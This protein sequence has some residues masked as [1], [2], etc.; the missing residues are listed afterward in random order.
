MSLVLDR[1]TRGPNEFTLLAM[2]KRDRNR[3]PDEFRAAPW[4]RGG[5]H[6]IDDGI[7]YLYVQ[8]HV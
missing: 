8:T 6:L 1:S 2:P 4:S 3:L 7:I 5:I